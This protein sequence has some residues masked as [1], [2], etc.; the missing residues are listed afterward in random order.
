MQS[1]HRMM[2]PIIMGRMRRLALFFLIVFVLSTSAIAFHHHA[3]GADH[4]NCPACAAAYCSAAVSGVFVLESPQLH[5]TP[6]PPFV[7]IP[8]DFIRF[9]A[10][11]SR[12]PPA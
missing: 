2:G 3:D 6:K 10:L 9:A 4:H 5:A 1:D 7:P 12:A 8:Y 11:L